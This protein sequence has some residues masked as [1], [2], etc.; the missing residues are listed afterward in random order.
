[1]N[2]INRFILA[3]Y[4]H[5]FNIHLVQLLVYLIL[6]FRYNLWTFNCAFGSSSAKV[7]KI[8]EWQKW[9]DLKKEEE[10]TKFLLLPLQHFHLNSH[11]FYWTS[12]IH[13]THR[14]S[15]IW[16]KTR[17]EKLL[18]DEQ[19]IKVAAVYILLLFETFQP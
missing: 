15:Y 1:M 8:M 3:I 4:F 12:T 5:C 10:E 16:R 11:K 18:D 9:W 19:W 2:E 7:E 17:I 13:F 6:W 14:N